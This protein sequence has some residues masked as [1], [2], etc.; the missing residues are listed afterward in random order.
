MRIIGP[1]SAARNTVDAVL[2]ALPG[3]DAR[4][5]GLMAPALWARG[6]QYGIDPVGVIAQSAKETAW[7]RFTGNVRPEF[8]NTGGIKIRHQALF[9]DITTG[10]NPL[11]HAMFPNWEVGAEAHAQHLRAYSGWPVDGLIVDP[12]YVFVNPDLK[13]ENFEDLGGRWAPSVQYGVELVT[14]A[15]TLQG[16]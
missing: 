13:L 12:R 4:F 2:A 11:A 10:D 16:R 3:V 1:P 14:I 5:R 9:P 8:Y 15:R 6:R 7:G